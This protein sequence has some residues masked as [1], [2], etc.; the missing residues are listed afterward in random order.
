MR[1]R[2]PWRRLPQRRRQRFRLGSSTEKKNQGFYENLEN[3]KIAKNILKIDKNINFG[4]ATQK[5]M[6]PPNSTQKT[7]HID[8]LSSLY[9]CKSPKIDSWHPQTIHGRITIVVYLKAYHKK[10]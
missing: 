5:R 9:D 6:S 7:T 3:E 10:I 2:P 4:G 1:I 8:L